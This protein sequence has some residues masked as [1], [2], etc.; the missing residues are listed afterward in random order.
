M[1]E[2]IWAMTRVRFKTTLSH[3]AYFSW[4]HTI[5]T[6]A[7]IIVIYLLACIG[8]Y[9]SLPPDVPIMV[10]II[11]FVILSTIMFSA[12]IVLAFP[13]AF[14]T[15]QISGKNKTMM[16]EH[17]IELYEDHFVSEDQYGRSELRWDIVQKLRR[18][19][20]F[21]IIYISKNSA[22]MI[23]RKAFSSDAD[24]HSF[25]RFVHTHCSA[26]ATG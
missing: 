15:T 20:S 26:S 21:I 13:L 17:S 6:P 8:A 16:T 24:W 18:T 14:V 3:L 12:L 2:E 19:R 22:M 7:L 10:D 25:Y 5:R 9:H 23:P 11:V 1:F 4:Y